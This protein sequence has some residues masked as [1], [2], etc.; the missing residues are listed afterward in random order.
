MYL[1]ITRHNVEN[2]PAGTVET[3]FRLKDGLNKVVLP[4]HLANCSVETVARR[5]WAIHGDGRYD[6]N[7]EL[8]SLEKVTFS[9]LT[10]GYTLQTADS[11]LTAAV[12]E[13]IKRAA[14]MIVENAIC[15]R[16][17]FKTQEQNIKIERDSTNGPSGNALPGIPEEILED[18]RKE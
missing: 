3:T 13:R 8:T 4:D 11:I 7:A 6:P 14:W 12:E 1:Y 16:Y 15:D 17:L 10:T 18:V 2:D 9:Q 5:W